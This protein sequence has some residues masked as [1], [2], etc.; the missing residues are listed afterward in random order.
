MND[1]RNG[2]I[3]KKYV[4]LKVILGKILMNLHA[5]LNLVLVQT[6]FLN[7]IHTS[8]A[9]NISNCLKYK[10]SIEV[11]EHLDICVF[12]LFIH[13]KTNFY[14]NTKTQTLNSSPYRVF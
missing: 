3:K 12:R 14:K 8:N 2:Q 1:K 9:L 5:L 11:I 6:K 4:L 10:Y 13:I 7:H